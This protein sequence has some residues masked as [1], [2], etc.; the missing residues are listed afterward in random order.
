MVAINK[1]TV[2]KL[3]GLTPAEVVILSDM[4][5]S[6]AGRDVVLDAEFTGESLLNDA[7]E[8]A[9]LRAKYKGAIVE[10]LWPGHSKNLPQTFESVGVK[11]RGLA[12]P[13]PVETQPEVETPVPVVEAPAKEK[14][15]KVT[16]SKLAI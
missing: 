5:K 4:F 15:P 16:K 11:V 3:K 14:A 2:L 9:R 10:K 7:G 8:V 6:K 12:K 1:E 13:V